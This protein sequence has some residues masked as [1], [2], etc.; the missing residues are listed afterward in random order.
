MKTSTQTKGE[1]IL[2][3]NYNLYSKNYLNVFTPLKESYNRFNSLARAIVDFKHS[4][5]D[6]PFYFCV[7]NFLIVTVVPSGLT[8]TVHFTESPR[9][10]PKNCV[11][12]FGIVVLRDVGFPLLI[13]D[14]YSNM[15]I[16]PCLLILSYIGMMFRILKNYLFSS[17]KK[18][19]LK[20]KHLY[21]R[22]I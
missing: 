9:F 7:S 1:S 13:F 15:V 5:K 12:S 14:L 11:T 19:K 17:I 3:T 18:G 4:F 6:V 2:V 10:T 8:S 21:S 20:G 16:P 22:L